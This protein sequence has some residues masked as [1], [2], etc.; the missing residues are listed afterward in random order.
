M[1]KLLSVA[2]PTYNMEK[3][4]NRCLDSFVIEDENLLNKLEVI[5]VNDGSKDSS[6]AIAHEYQQKYP[7]VFS[8]IDKENGHYG[9]CIN[10]ALKVA[11]GKYFRIVDSDDWVD[12]NSLTVLME[13]LSN[14]EEDCLFT[15][16]TVHDENK[17]EKIEQ[18]IS[19]L[20]WN[21]TIDLHTFEM[22]LNCIAM[23]NLTYKRALLNAIEY[24]QTTGICY[25]DSEYVYYPF[26]QADTLYCYDMSLYQYYI[27]RGEQ[28]M[29]PATLEKNFSH[30]QLL[31]D[32]FQ[33]YEVKK[34]NCN[35][36]RIFCHYL[37]LFV[38]Y[39]LQVHLLFDNNYDEKRDKYI[40]L[41]V[42]KLKIEEPVVY[43]SLLG[44]KTHHVPYVR[45]WNVNSFYGRLIHSLFVVYNK[46]KNL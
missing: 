24:K 23:H 9:S 12:T 32:S 19:G 17:N 21:K 33:K 4:L 26:S 42:T 43:K 31:F 15:K 30:F 22:P 28:S 10:A 35:H 44:I 27:G 25:T 18:D 8:V 39:M 34:S 45:I 5:V 7:D 14:R 2:I 41:I 46:T 29:N 37:R 36:Y 38:T 11:T 13:D 6:S 20:V 40:R 3:Y 16:F 1:E